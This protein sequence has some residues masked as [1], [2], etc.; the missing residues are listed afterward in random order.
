[1]RWKGSELCVLCG[2][3]E[4]VD[5]LFFSCPLAAF[6]WTFVSEALGWRDHPK[7]MNELIQE[8]LP[9]K[10][11]VSYQTSISC[12]AG[13]TWAIWKTRNKMVI[14]KTFPETSL[15]IVYL[16]LSFTLLAVSRMHLTVIAMI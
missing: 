10:F 3:S 5:H 2:C 12:F 1:M 15:D 4:D 14:Q 13:L 11:G 9:H 8:W 16:G 7:L 6:M